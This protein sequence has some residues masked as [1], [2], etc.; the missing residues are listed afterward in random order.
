MHEALPDMTPSIQGAIMRLLHV[1]CTNCAM[2]CNCPT[3]TRHVPQLPAPPQFIVL[4]HMPWY[5]S[6]LFASSVLRM[7][8]PDSV[9]M[10]EE[11]PAGE[12]TSIVTMGSAVASAARTT[13]RSLGEATLQ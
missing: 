10:E 8:S 1:A 3:S 9:V 11:V 2:A 6:T 5:S 12:V 13:R 7:I 4:A